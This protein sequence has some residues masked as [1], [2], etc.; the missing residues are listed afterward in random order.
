MQLKG[1]TSL[2]FEKLPFLDKRFTIED[3]LT[4]PFKEVDGLYLP[5]LIGGPINS[6][7]SF[8]EIYLDALAELL[9]TNSVTARKTLQMPVYPYNMNALH[10]FAMTHNAEGV[11]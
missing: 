1:T 3:S 9:D 10:Y 4:S 5:I 2:L 6:T 11:T 8:A 7:G